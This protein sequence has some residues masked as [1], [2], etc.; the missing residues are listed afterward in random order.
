M[1]NKII[2][3]VIICIVLLMIFSTIPVTS[4][5]SII[6]LKSQPIAEKKKWTLM[7]YE[8]EDFASNTIAS[9]L[10]LDM[11]RI[12]LAHSG[13]NLNVIVLRD[14]VYGPGNYWYI[15]E[16]GGRKL[17]KN[18]SEVDM[19]SYETL[20]NFVSY[21]KENFPAEHYILDFFDHGAGWM[22][23][24]LDETNKSWLNMS[25]IRKALTE[26]GGLDIVSFIS[27]CFLATVESVY[28]LRDCVEVYVGKQPDALCSIHVIGP[29]CDL[30]NEDYDLSNIEIGKKI[31]D[32]YKEKAD[33]FPWSIVSGK[34]LS[35]MRTDEVTGLVSEINNLSIFLI[36]N[37]DECLEDIR[38]VV[39]ET[40]AFPTK[41][42]EA[43]EWYR[44]RGI[45]HF[46]HIDIYDFVNNYLK[47][48]GISETLRNCLEKVMEGVNKTVIAENHTHYHPNAH[49]LNVYFPDTFFKEYEDSNLDFITNTS[50][51][52]FIKKYHSFYATVDDDGNT[53]YTSIQGAI[54]NSSDGSVIYIKNGVYYE[55]II[56]NKSITFSGESRDKTIID[57]NQ[58]G[59][60]VTINADDVRLFYLGINNSGDNSAGILVHGNSTTIKTCNITNNHLGL[61]M[62]NSSNNVIIT[63]NIKNNY[64]GIYLN[65]SNKNK[66]NNNRLEGNKIDVRFLDS[67]K[68]TWKNKYLD[69]QNE[70]ISLILGFRTI[71]ILKKTFI[72]PWFNLNL[73]Y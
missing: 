70:N 30:L 32:F 28:E 14:T 11:A 52:E 19:G 1:K 17:L 60:V 16:Y 6:T 49:G 64:F 13:K 38:S 62:I 59:D 26:T 36:N 9:L 22:G 48:E 33:V 3:I 53:G 57:G 12:S 25:E 68:N 71:N 35:A 73:A 23:T 45:P 40:E 51:D 72:F 31:I 39:N 8:D 43:P 24:G 41:R 58:I 54:D 55:N 21:C 7:L 67:Y 44:A 29:L 65:C 4:S 42:A 15:K 61:Y 37:I 50:W 27:P 69:R 5:D 18:L 46:V 63:N 10:G 2:G 47:I 20:R 34:T 66:F 56:I